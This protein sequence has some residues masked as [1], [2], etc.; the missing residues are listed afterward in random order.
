MKATFMLL[1]AGCV[2]AS[3]ITQLDGPVSWTGAGGEVREALTS[4]STL[5]ASGF[6]QWNAPGKIAP[7][8]PLELR[9][10]AIYTINTDAGLE[11]ESVKVISD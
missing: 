10:V 5:P 1:G 7:L 9:H 8:Q 11:V 6:R 4:G 2:V 3:S